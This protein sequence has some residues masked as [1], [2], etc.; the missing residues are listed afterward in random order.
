LAEDKSA[1]LAP[2]LDEMGQ[3]LL[4]LRLQ[5]FP[6]VDFHTSLEPIDKIL[7]RSR[8][9]GLGAGVVVLCGP[10]SICTLGDDKSAEQFLK[11]MHDEPVFVGMHGTVNNWQRRFSPEMIA[12]FD[13]V[14]A[15]AAVFTDRLQGGFKFNDLG[16]VKEIPDP[17]RF[18]DELVKTIEG[19]LDHEPID[20]FAN[21]TYLP[22]AIA[23]DYDKLWTPEWGAQVTSEPGA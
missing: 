16:Q 11:A 12:R 23:K 6:L 4:R 22:A 19:I 20:I 8:Q 14:M 7:T 10:G 15:D 18:M 21:A 9:T 13:Y 1:A 5:G 3:R 17:Q 2:K